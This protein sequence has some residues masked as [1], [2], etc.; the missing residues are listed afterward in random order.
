MKKTV[1]IDLSADRLIAVAAD[2]VDDHN[3]IRALKMLNKNSREEGDDEDSLMLYAEIFDDLGLCEKCI[4][5]WFRYMDEASSDEGM[6]ECY[7]GLAVNYMNI[8]KPQFSA[9]YYN[10]LLF[11]THDVDDETRADILKDFLSEEENPLKFVWPP[12]LADCSEIIKEGIAHLRAGDYEKAEEAF[13]KVHEDNPRYA[14]A[15]NYIAMCKII[16]DKHNEAEQECLNILK[17]FPENVQAMSTL[18]AVKCEVGETNEALALTDRLLKIKTDNQDEIFKIV[19]VCAENKLHAEAYRQ[20]LKL[21]GEIVYE[22]PVMFF[23]AVSAYNCGK[24]KESLNAFNDLITLYPD[25]MT[26]RYYYDLVRGGDFKG[27]L[28]Y[29]YR[30]PQEIRESSLRLISDFIKLPQSGVKSFKLKRE[31]YGCIKW[32]LDECGNDDEI[33]ML[34]AQVSVKAG[35][36]DVV[37]DIL[38]DAFCDDALKIETL[39]RLARRNEENEFGL[40]VY[41]IYKCVSTHKLAIGRT[42]RKIFVDAYAGLLAHFGI[43]G[44]ENG[45]GIARAAEFVYDKLEVE[46]RLNEVKS[47]DVLSAAIFILSGVDERNVT[48]KDICRFFGVKH[49]DVYNL[50]GEI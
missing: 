6:A 47:Q 16:C 5:A 20:I 32:C 46:G 12:K 27:E 43:L 17:K 26:A 48:G 9:F 42:K 23:K 25:A 49:A 31:L 21:Y 4:N 22:K 2:L 10:K 14:E 13:N 41:H 3:Y 1:D 18:T 29:Y 19:T 33:K 34:A 50:I 7:E 28:T 37:R 44:E 8:D 40:T 11:E 30:L 24:L 38:L 36:D 35:F 15:R 39:V 45:D